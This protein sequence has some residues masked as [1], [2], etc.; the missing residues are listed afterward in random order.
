MIEVPPRLAAKVAVIGLFC[1]VGMLH[2]G[3]ANLLKPFNVVRSAAYSIEILGN[4][5][6]VCI[7][8]REKTH[9][10]V[11]GVA[12]GY[13]YGQAALGPGNPSLVQ[14]RHVPSDDIRSRVKTFRSTQRLPGSRI[15]RAVAQEQKQREREITQ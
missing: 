5:R 15:S 7:W 9:D 14:V 4:G 8:H 1:P 11:S 3:L 10:R 6:M 13:S 2:P 12:R